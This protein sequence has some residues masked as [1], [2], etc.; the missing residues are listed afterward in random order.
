M[1]ESSRSFGEATDDP[2]SGDPADPLYDYPGYQDGDVEHGMMPAGQAV[3]VIHE[4]RPAGE[5]VRS[6]AGAAA[7]KTYRCPGCQQVIPPGLAHLVTWPAEPAWSS[8]SGLEERRH[9]H[10]SCWQRRP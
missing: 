4:I 2:Q 6:I 1:P 10:N 7:T 8:G 5:I 3:E 9:W